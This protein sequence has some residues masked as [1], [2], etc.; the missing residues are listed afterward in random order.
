MAEKA[1]DGGALSPEVASY[2][3]QLGVPLREH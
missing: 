1:R 3:R 2:L